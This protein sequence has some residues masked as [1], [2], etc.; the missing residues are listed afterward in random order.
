MEKIPLKTVM[1]YH[2]INTSQ[3]LPET[4][5]ECKVQSNFEEVIMVSEG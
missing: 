2:S 4:G 1:K 3:P 5:Y